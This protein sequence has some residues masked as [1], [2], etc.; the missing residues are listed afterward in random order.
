MSSYVVYKA[1]VGRPMHTL[2]A[3]GGATGLIV[4]SFGS[5]CSTVEYCEATTDMASS[6][7][8]CSF[9]AGDNA[10]V[11]ASYRALPK[12]INGTLKF[13]SVEVKR[14]VISSQLGSC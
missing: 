10:L 12:K 5:E 11:S 8:M 7:D 1:R 13:S 9:D 2:G 3:G 4:F 14:P 6:R